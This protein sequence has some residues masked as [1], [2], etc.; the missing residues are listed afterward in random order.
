[1]NSDS[2]K[3]K[4]IDQITLILIISASSTK[5]VKPFKIDTT[6]KFN[7]LIFKRE[8]RKINKKICILEEKG[9]H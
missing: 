2:L 5:T 6:S 7:C 4:A 9:T 3:I 8:L 1:M